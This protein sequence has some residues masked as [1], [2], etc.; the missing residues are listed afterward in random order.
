MQHDTLL[1]NFL[2]GVDKQ[3][4]VSQLSHQPVELDV[5]S[6]VFGKGRI[7]IAGSETELLRAGSISLLLAVFQKCTLKTG[8]IRRFFSRQFIDCQ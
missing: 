2:R 6:R 3:I 1:E 7:H 5:G 8:P 4:I